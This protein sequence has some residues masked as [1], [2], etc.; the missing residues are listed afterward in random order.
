MIR[1]G[2]DQHFDNIMNFDQKWQNNR[3]ESDHVA[4]KWLFGN[5]RGP[6]T[7][8]GARWITLAGGEDALNLSTVLRQSQTP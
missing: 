8:R 1:G 4:L 7:V 3:I 5:R 6:V 2:Y